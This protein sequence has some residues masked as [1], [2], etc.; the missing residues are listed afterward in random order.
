MGFAV[1]LRIGTGTSVGRV[2]INP[3]Q[4]SLAVN[5]ALEDRFIFFREPST[6]AGELILHFRCDDYDERH[7]IKP[8]PMYNAGNAPN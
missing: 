6:Y 4:P 2:Y 7:P 8:K 5:F 3:N 1:S